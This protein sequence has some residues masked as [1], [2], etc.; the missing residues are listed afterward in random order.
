MNTAQDNQRHRKA[1]GYTTAICA[2][3]LL[4]FVFISWKHLPPTKPLIQEEIAV[5]LGEEL[6]LG[7]EIDGYG[8]EQPDIKGEPEP[9]PP[10]A[11]ARPEPEVNNEQPAPQTEAPEPTKEVDEVEDEDAAPIVKPVAKPK[12]VVTP[13]PVVNPTPKPVV[14][15]A[16]NPSPKPTPSPAAPKPRVPKVVYPGAGNGGGNGA[17]QDNGYTMQGNN[18]NGKGDAGD[19]NGDRDSYGNKP[20]GSKG[21][22][23]GPKII[24]GNRKIVKYYSFTGDLDKATINAVIKVAPNGAG[25][26][27]RIAQGS[28]STS[29]AYANAIK[30]YL[31]N[32]KFDAAEE[33][34]IVTVQ[35]NFNVN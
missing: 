32:I 3:L 10:Q 1:L 7:N 35:F 8:E 19:R 5:D 12:P 21:T 15:P 2:L 28:T 23:G 34:S 33:E 18:K 31:P 4:A 17:Q 14:K 9:A 27:V 25:T 6:N 22:G 29:A 24:S 26:F 16:A 11:G 20:G 30:N 13:K